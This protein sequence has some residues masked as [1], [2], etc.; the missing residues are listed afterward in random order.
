MTGPYYKSLVLQ[1]TIGQNF[2]SDFAKLGSYG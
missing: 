1:L 2:V